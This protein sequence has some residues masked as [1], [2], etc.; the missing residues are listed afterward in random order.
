MRNIHILTDN[1]Y[2]IIKNFLFYHICILQLNKT[3]CQNNH[4]LP[5]YQKNT[6]KQL[7]LEIY[8]NSN[9]NI[10][11]GKSKLIMFYNLPKYTYIHIH[12]GPTKHWWSSIHNKQRSMLSNL[13]NL[14]K[15]QEKHTPLYQHMYVCK[16]F[17]STN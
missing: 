11:D 2:L 4:S 8:Y 9:L 14:S 5:I 7:T 13:N 12:R 6:Q 3:H 16:Y 1:I 10:L 17:A 15:Y